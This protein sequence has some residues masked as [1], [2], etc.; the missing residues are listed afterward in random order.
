MASVR[1][2]HT[3]HSAGASVNG[4]DAGNGRGGSLSKLA[5]NVKQGMLGALFVTAK[6]VQAKDTSLHVHIWRD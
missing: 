3:A 1:S 2:A 4:S 6:K 5:A